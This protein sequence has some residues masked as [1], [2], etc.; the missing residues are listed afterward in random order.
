MANHVNAHIIWD[1][2]HAVGIIP[3]NLSE[4]EVDFAIGCTYKYLCCCSGS[5]AFLYANKKHHNRCSQPITGWIGSECP[6]K[7]DIKYKPAKGITQFLT[8]AQG[9]LPTSIVNHNLD[10]FMKADMKFIR[11]KSL[12]LSDLLIELIEKLCPSLKLVSPREHKKRGGHISFEHPNGFAISK[13]CKE[14]KVICDY[15]HP[16]LVRFALAPL[17]LRFVDIWDS[18]KIISFAVENAEYKVVDVSGV[19]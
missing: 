13:L 15:R 2:S 18:A 1:L 11:E 6:F 12:A 4:I 5:P 19:S 7:M 9:V 14:M 8:G 16:N 3:I 17:Y 10:I